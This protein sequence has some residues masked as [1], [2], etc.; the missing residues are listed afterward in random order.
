M[1]WPSSPIT[2][3]SLMKPGNCAFSPDN[4]ASF[5]AL[6]AGVTPMA[7]QSGDLPYL[8]HLAPVDQWQTGAQRQR[9][10][11]RETGSWAAVVQQAVAQLNGDIEQLMPQPK[12]AAG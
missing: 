8:Q 5:A 12:T 10:L 3:I 6:S 11:Y 9:R 1:F 7:R 2:A 4:S